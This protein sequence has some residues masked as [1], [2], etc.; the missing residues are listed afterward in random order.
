MHGNLIG[1]ISDGETGAQPNIAIAPKVQATIDMQ[2][3]HFLNFDSSKRQTLETQL[4]LSDTDQSTEFCLKQCRQCR[5]FYAKGQNNYDRAY[6][7]KR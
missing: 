4:K 6:T 7:R 5:P 2:T 1:M 3:H